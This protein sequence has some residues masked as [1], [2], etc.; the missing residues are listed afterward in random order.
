M[1]HSREER[2]RKRRKEG[3][4]RKKETAKEAK[5]LKLPVEIDLASFTPLY[6]CSRCHRVAPAGGKILNI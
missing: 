1:L 3:E 2:E 6:T 4:G 5:V